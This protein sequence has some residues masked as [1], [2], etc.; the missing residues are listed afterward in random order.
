MRSRGVA[1]PRTGPS[2]ALA[3]SVGS[4]ALVG[5]GVGARSL[6]RDETVSL[7]R[8]GYEFGQNRFSRYG[9]DVVRT[10]LM[11]RPAV[12]V[13]GQE[14][15][16]EFYQ[17]GRMTRR[18]ALPL[19]ALTLLLDRRSV[20]LLDGDDHRWR[21]RMFLSLMTP[22][23]LDAIADMV[24][25]H[26]RT[27]LQPGPGGRRVVLLDEVHEVLCQAVCE[28]SGVPLPAGQVQ[29]RTREFVSMFEGA[30][31]VG[32]RNWR[33]Q[34]LRH[35]TERWVRGLVDQARAGTLRPPDGSALHVVATHRDRDGQLLTTE[36]AAVELINVLRPT[37]AVGRFV[38]YAALAL[39]EHP[40]WRERVRDDE[41]LRWFVQEVRRYY[42]FFPLV[43]G[44]VVDGFTWRGER[45]R[46]G[47]WLLLDLYATDRDS[48]TWDDPDAFRPERFRDRAVGPF[49]L[50]PQ[51]GGDHETDHRCAGEW[52]AIRLTERAI[53]LL[54]DGPPWEVPP[55]D[56]RIDLSRMPAKPRSGLVV[57]VR[58]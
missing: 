33:G 48:R 13:H 8:E 7:L 31:A 5:L 27:R 18:R 37:I 10:R 45:F 26:W 35:R 32:P 57:D 58:P 47:D 20:A 40:E 22:V 36:T 11:L 55:Q 14:A 24:E 56:L 15:A 1:T 43:G 25:R 21:K 4:A 46:R 19:T 49:E 38:I 12:L 44:R 17:P 29:E 16:R 23:A 3:V 6:A 51:G 54:A 2:R 39:H 42:P 41:Q 28:W 53:R 9:S 34:M 52:L 50:V 30:G